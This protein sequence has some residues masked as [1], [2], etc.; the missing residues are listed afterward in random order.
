MGRPLRGRFAGNP[1]NRAAKCPVLRGK[2]QRTRG[3]IPA[4]RTKPADPSRIRP[5]QRGKDQRTPVGRTVRGGPACGAG[6]VAG[7]EGR[8]GVAADVLA[9][10]QEDD[11]AGDRRPRGRRTA[12]RTGRARR[13]PRPGPTPCRQVGASRAVNSSRCRSSIRSSSTS[14]WRARST[15]RSRSTTP[16]LVGQV[17]ADPAHPLDD[18]PHVGRDHVRRDA[19][20]GRP[21]R[22]GSPARP[23]AACRRRSRSPRHDD[24]QVGGDRRLEGEQFER[25][26]LGVRPHLVELDVGGDHLLGQGQI[27]IQQRLGGVTQRVAGDLAHR[28]TV[29]TQIGEPHLVG[30]SH[31]LQQ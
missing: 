2:D 12:R 31:D 6:S 21:W 13:C 20:A 23:S 22:R 28:R 26:L 15:S 11:P 16:G 30:L 7:G 10:H 25:N 3:P 9:G 24:P 1:A 17:H 19:G 29:L 27:G 14:S 8:G 5:V 18:R 4:P